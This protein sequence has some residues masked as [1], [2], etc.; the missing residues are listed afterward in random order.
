MKDNRIRLAVSAAIFD[1]TGKILLHKRRKENAWCIVSGHV[2]FGETVEQA[3]IREIKEETGVDAK[4]LGL[5]G[6]YSSPA[7]QLYE[8]EDGSVQYVTV[9]FEVQ[10]LQQL[11]EQISND[12]TLDVRFFEVTALPEDLA[13]INPFWLDDVLSKKAQP[14]YR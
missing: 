2:E 7:F 10:L 6:V 1:D 8:T 12:E 11:P 14:F 5:I 13:K 9:Y 4:V 3:I